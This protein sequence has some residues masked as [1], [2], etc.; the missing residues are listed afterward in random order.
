V[1]E[2]ERVA[3]QDSRIFLARAFEYG[4]QNDVISS[5]RLDVLHEQIVAISNKLITVRV[6]DSS[7]KYE[8]QNWVTNAFG[9]ISLGLEYA[10]SNG[11]LAKAA[12]LLNQNKLIKFFQIGNTL[13]KRLTEHARQVKEDGVL[14]SPV[15]D[16]QIEVTREEVKIYNTYEGLFLEEVMRLQLNIDHADVVLESHE[17]L[18]PVIAMEDLNLAKL[19]LNNLEL[20][21][22]YYR[23]LPKD[24]IFDADFTALEAIDSSEMI[25]QALMIN[26]ALYRQLEF[27]VNQEDIDNF[28]DI[29][30]DDE[31]NTIKKET[32]HLLIGWIGHFLDEAGQSEEVK[33]Y[34]V[35]YWRY[36]LEQLKEI[37]KSV[38]TNVQS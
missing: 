3:N 14:V 37:L 6:R 25:T 36:C 22:K 15:T 31:S 10:T 11:D 29:F 33:R 9:L 17:K 35:Q 20:R 34:T 30:Y 4:V 7:S 23:I 24:K 13:A 18:R 5:D 27:H 8:I 16:Q 19:M 12:K 1:F 21:S 38:D 26:L 32:V 28:H 2:I